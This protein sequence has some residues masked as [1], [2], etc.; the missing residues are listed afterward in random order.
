MEVPEG[1]QMFIWIWVIRSKK[2]VLDGQNKN[3]EYH[4]EYVYS[5]NG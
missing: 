5:I 4:D 3:S 1:N 2:P